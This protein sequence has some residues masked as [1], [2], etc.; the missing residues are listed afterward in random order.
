M[1]FSRILFSFAKSFTHY[2]YLY[3]QKTDTLICTLRLVG[4]F[5]KNRLSFGLDNRTN[6][7]ILYKRQR[8]SASK[9]NREIIE[10]YGG[11]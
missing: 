9:S 3:P 10:R 1:S 5:W 7:K 11:W 8:E 4:E 6:V 2:I